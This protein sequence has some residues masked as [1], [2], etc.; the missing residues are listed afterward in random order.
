MKNFM[1]D[2]SRAQRKIVQR[3]RNNNNGFAPKTSARAKELFVNFCEHAGTN[4]ESKLRI[5]SL[6]KAGFS[7]GAKRK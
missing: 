5:E 7:S 4:E 2:C 3:H 1:K 6:K